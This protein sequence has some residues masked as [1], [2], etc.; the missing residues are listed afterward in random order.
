MIMKKLFSFFIGMFICS[1]VVNA[2]EVNDST[3]AVFQQVVTQGVTS[4][5]TV[6]FIN[7][8]VYPWSYSDGYIKSTNKSVK[9][10]KSEFSFTYTSSYQTQVQFEWINYYTSYHTLEC[11]VDGV[12]RNNNTSTSAWSQ[13]FSLPAGTHVITFRDSVSSNSSN[14]DRTSGVHAIRIFEVR[15]LEEFLLTPESTPVSFQNDSIYPWIVDNDYAVCGNYWYKSSSSVLSASFTI[16]EPSL[17]TFQAEAYAADSY[18]NSSSYQ[19][20]SVFIDGIEVTGWQ[21]YNATSW[22]NFSSFLGAGTH[23]IE[24]KYDIKSSYDACYV[25]LR[26]VAVTP[27]MT[28]VELE[29][30]GTLGVEVLY[31]HDV[32]TDVRALKV[33]GNLNSTDWSTIK[34]MTNLKGLDLSEASFTSIPADQF[35][36]RSSLNYIV[37]PEGLQTIGNNAFYSASLWSI[38]IPASVTSLGESAFRSNPYMHTV[39]F[40]EGSQLQ[41]IGAYCFQESGVK[42]I[43]LPHTVTS[44]GNY[45]FYKCGALD[46]LIL[47]DALTSLPTEMCEDCTNLSYVQFPHNLNTIN[48]YCFYNAKKLNHL[49]LP[50]GLQTI[51]QYAFRNCISLDTLRLPIKLLSLA[52]NVFEGCTALKYIELPSSASV[53][54]SNTFKSC[55][56]VQTVVCPSATPPSIS[57]DPFTSGRAKSAITLQVPSVSVA[58]YKLNSYWYQFG[59]IIEGED[60]DYWYI[61]GDL[62]LTNNRRMSGTPDIKIERGGKLTVGGAAPMPVGTLIFNTSGSSTAALNN[63]CPFMTVDSAIACYYVEAN[64]WYFILPM[65]DVDLPKVYHTGNGQYIF[66]YYNAANRASKGIGSSWQNVT[67]AYLHRGQ[68]YILQSNTAGWI[69]MPPLNHSDTMMLTTEDVTISLQTHASESAA[70]ESWN[71]IGNPYPCYYDIWYMDYTAPI[72]VWTGS[73]YKAYS[74]ADDNYAL[75]PM[76]AFFVQKP[77]AV[78]NLIFHKE[79]RQVTTSISHSNTADAPRRVAQNANRKVYNLMLTAPN[80]LSDETR[81]VINDAASMDYELTCDASKFMSMDADCPQLYTM[82]LNGN[83]LA[84]NERPL[85]N[86]EVSLGVQLPEIG[87]YTF[88]SVSTQD[89]TLVDNLLGLTHDLH[90]APYTFSTDMVGENNARFSLVFG[91]RPVS[92]GIENLNEQGH[93]EGGYVYTLDGRIAGYLSASVDVQSLNLSAGVYMVRAGNEYTKIVI[94]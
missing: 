7:D 69:H 21:T 36:D 22:R 57:S 11:Y 86:G 85:A 4:V 37:L 43:S 53:G 27:V 93:L 29:Y 75:R 20:L 94:R 49:R 76:E 87:E 54:Y 58:S 10:S 91:S 67:E 74:L 42:S 1:L 73:T 30:A 79:G 9:N 33:K 47:S 25:L 90:N 38:R 52:Q 23:T 31:K 51:Q 81:V 18:Y 48:S 8:D 71:Y 35:K 40:A 16:A 80:G 62:M 50:E 89:I 5:D 46:T 19:L 92:T 78:D 83:R 64:K 63:M 41:T 13:Q 28:E 3:N 55:T 17:L 82:D 39:E 34:Q 68:G 70:N 14:Y 15:P 56:A 84:I 60:P 77:E 72:T 59:T 2:A 6:I 45:G 66:R 24:W 65:Y 44:I 88:A 12:Y 26:D 61:V 32:L